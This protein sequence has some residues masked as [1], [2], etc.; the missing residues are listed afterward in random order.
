MKVGIYGKKFDKL[1]QNAVIE[2]ISKLQLAA[3]EIA[4][5]DSFYQLINGKIKLS[6]EITT[7]SESH[8]IENKIDFLFSL[9]GDGTLLETLA[10][11]KGSGIPILGINTGRLGFFIQCIGT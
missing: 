11:V 8:H 6:S 4:V 10:L 9:G 5:N 3:I 1:N 7:F 2:L